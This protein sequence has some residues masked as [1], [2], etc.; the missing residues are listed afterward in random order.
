[1]LVETCFCSLHAMML[2]SIFSTA[3]GGWLW[4]FV[5][6][7]QYL[8]LG[9]SLSFYWQD[10]KAFCER[11]MLIYFLQKVCKKFCKV[12]WVMTKCSVD[13]EGKSVTAPKLPLHPQVYSGSLHLAVDFTGHYWTH[14]QSVCYRLNFVPHKRYTK[15]L[16]PSTSECELIWKQDHC[17]CN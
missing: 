8:Y 4:T 13:A 1:M 12:W 6:W 5:T 3:S 14:L 15:A 2:W 16:S 10:W 17:K 9:D 11:C 7:Y